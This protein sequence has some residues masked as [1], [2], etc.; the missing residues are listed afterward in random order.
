MTRNVRVRLNSRGVQ[1]LLK[2][3]GLIQACNEQANK[4]LAKLG[5]GYRSDTH[6]GKV[7]GNAAVWA[8]SRQAR[9]DARND[10]TIWK[11]VMGR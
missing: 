3:E 5:N 2:D 1:S 10:D 9:R 11:A 8:S 7:R 4:A 6:V